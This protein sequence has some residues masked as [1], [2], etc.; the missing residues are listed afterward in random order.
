MMVGPLNLTIK[1]LVADAEMTSRTPFVALL[2]PIHHSAEPRQ[3]FKAAR[4]WCQIQSARY[5]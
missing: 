5:R 1:L 2:S 4:I 3:K